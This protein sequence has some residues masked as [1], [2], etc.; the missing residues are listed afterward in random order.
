MSPA[1][2]QILVV[3][4]DADIVEVVD[5]ILSSRGYTVLT[6]R[7]GSQALDLLRQGFRP[8]VILLDLMMPVM[9]GWEFR[10]AQLAEP[11]WAQIPVVALSGDQRAVGSD[12]NMG[13]VEWLAKPVTLAQLLALVERLVPLGGGESGGVSPDVAPGNPGG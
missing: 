13:R 5:L 4:D 11:A 6:A 1:K 7:N 8:D 10:A 9:N 2:G 3:D 12:E